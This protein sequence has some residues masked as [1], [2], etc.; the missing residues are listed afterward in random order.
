MARDGNTMGTLPEM[1]KPPIPPAAISLDRTSFVPFYRQIADQVREMIQSGKIPPGQPFWSE[2]EIS[3]DLGI[4]K[5]TVRQAF[6]ILRAEGLLTVS[7]GKRPL[8]A[9]GRLQKNTQE[10]RGF[11][12]EMARRGL[13]PSSKLLVIES[14]LPEPEIS[15]ALKLDKDAEVYK[16]QRLRLADNQPVGVETSY[17]P[18]RLFRGLERQDLE[19]KSLYSTLEAH[20]GVKLDWSEEVL[21]ARAAGKGEADLLQVR[22]GSPLFFMRRK[23]YSADGAPVEYGLSLFR[24]DR[25]SATVI[26]RRKS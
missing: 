6:Q 25:Y 12:E 10:L 21:E 11:T 15:A 4:S 1:P 17:L 3:S 19:N 2:G 20:Y 14:V 16:I 8:V 7:K 22:R 9:A 23:V 24:G 5:M 26:S 18:A 13:K